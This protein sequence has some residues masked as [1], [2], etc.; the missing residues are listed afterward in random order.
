[1]VPQTTG[2]ALPGMT[3]SEIVAALRSRERARVEPALAQLAGAGVP[4]VIAFGPS[5]DHAQVLVASA[6]LF[7]NDL[8]V[9]LLSITCQLA[10]ALGA[11]VVFGVAQ[12]P[13]RKTKGGLIVPS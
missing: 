8:F 4:V 13:P 11:S 10:N 3:D 1:M 9:W 5:K 7:A 2:P 6:A 12:A